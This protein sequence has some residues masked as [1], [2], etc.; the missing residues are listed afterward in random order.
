VI[1]KEAE[2]TLKNKE[3][4]N[5]K[6]AHAERINKSETSN[7]RGSWNNLKIIQKMPEQHTRKA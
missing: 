7:N 4:I 5:R 6:M 3:L 1:K 2:K